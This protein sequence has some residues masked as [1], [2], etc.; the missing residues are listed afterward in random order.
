MIKSQ[1]DNY[2]I[3]PII[4]SCY[5]LN[6]PIISYTPKEYAN[7]VISNVSPLLPALN[8]L[9]KYPIGITEFDPLSLLLTEIGKNL[10]ELFRIN[11]KINWSF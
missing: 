10:T 5:L 8:L 4:I 2:F 7:I 3:I 1:N 11:V 6:N 9:P